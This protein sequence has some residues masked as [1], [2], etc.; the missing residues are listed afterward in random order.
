MAQEYEITVKLVQLVEGGDKKKLQGASF[1]LR[2][3]S[4]NL[5]TGGSGG[6]L[7]ARITYIDNATVRYV[8]P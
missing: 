4:D 2:G 6:P 7:K 5:G 3:S 8:S 1:T